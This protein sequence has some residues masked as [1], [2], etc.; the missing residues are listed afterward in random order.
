MSKDERTAL[1]ESVK[2]M[3]DMFAIWRTLQKGRARADLLMRVS[4]TRGKSCGN[5]KRL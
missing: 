3:E 4:G 5:A 2:S 1:V